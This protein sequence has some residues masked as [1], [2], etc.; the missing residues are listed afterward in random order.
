[1]SIAIVSI[2]QDE[3]AYVGRWLTSLESAGRL[4]DEIV[5]VDGGSTD[6]T[7]PFLRARGVRVVECPFTGDFAAQRNR[8]IEEARAPWIFEVD[9]DEI[10]STTLLAG[11]HTIAANGDRDRVDCIG[12]PRLNFLDGRLVAGPGHKGLDFQYRLHHRRV[13]WCGAVH[14]ETVGWTNR[15]ELGIAQGHFLIH[16]K[17]SARHEARNALYRSIPR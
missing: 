10:P 15:V 7:V 6:D 17:A 16:D 3:S 4:F 13:R 9:A 12:V 8:A 14:E 11:L 2:M 5:V 1:M